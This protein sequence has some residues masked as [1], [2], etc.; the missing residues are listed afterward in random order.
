[1][2]GEKMR[3]TPLKIFAPIVAI[4][5]MALGNTACTTDNKSKCSEM[6]HTETV[7]TLNRFQNSLKEQY[8]L[9]NQDS[10]DFLKYSKDSVT[11]K[12]QS[13]KANEMKYEYFRKYYNYATTEE[14]LRH[15][16]TDELI[17]LAHRYTLD[18]I[19]I[20]QAISTMDEK[21]F[22]KFAAEYI[23]IAM[24]GRLKRRDS[25]YSA[26]WH[27]AD[28]LGKLEYIAK[29]KKYADSKM[30]LMQEKE[31]LD[32]E[33]QALY[34]YGKKIVD[35]SSKAEIDLEM[36]KVALNAAKHSLKPDE[37]QALE[38]KMDSLKKRIK[39]LEKA[40]NALYLLIEAKRAQKGYAGDYMIRSNNSPY[41]IEV[42]MNSH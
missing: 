20:D 30:R 12:A 15:Y 24:D 18:K 9:V 10:I 29:G 28:S 4:G 41:Q 40:Q 27:M 1:M 21:D 26:L 5:A 11:I 8:E 13:A 14:F 34:D 31:L 3:L 39:Q 42:F 2:K 6:K 32:D 16:T 25:H 36:T 17:V 37:K 23:I 7:D 22:R 38:Q 19:T 33:M 35:E